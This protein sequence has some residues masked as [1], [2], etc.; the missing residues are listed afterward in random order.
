MTSAN[1]V[2]VDGREA[3]DTAVFSYFQNSIYTIHSVMRCQRLPGYIAI[4]QC[5]SFKILTMRLTER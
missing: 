4:A 1:P 5:R 3:G 2:T